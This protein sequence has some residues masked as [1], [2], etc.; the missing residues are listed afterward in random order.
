MPTRPRAASSPPASNAPVGFSIDGDRPPMP[1]LLH[2][3]IRKASQPTEP[4]PPTHRKRDF[5]RSIASMMDVRPRRKASSTSSSITLAPSSVSLHNEALS[6]PPSSFISPSF[7]SLSP[8]PSIPAAHSSVTLSSA[9]SNS[10]SDISIDDTTTTVDDAAPPSPTNTGGRSLK[11]MMSIPLIKFWARTSLSPTTF[12]P[13][14]SAEQELL[15]STTTQTT[16][17]RTTTTYQTPYSQSHFYQSESNISSNMTDTPPPLPVTK[18]S[19]NSPFRI[20][21][22]SPKPAPLPHQPPK[23][24]PPVQPR[25]K[26]K[27]FDQKR[28]PHIPSFYGAKAAYPGSTI[29]LLPILS[30]HTLPNTLTSED[31]SPYRHIKHDSETLPQKEPVPDFEAMIAGSATIKVSLTPEELEPMV[32]AY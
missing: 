15:P 4:P 2:P 31:S 9:K 10:S 29:A 24:D 6:P 22:R 1:M 20:R 14:P 32:V 18:H 8:P 27:S 13:P 12:T 16:A 23:S 28:R 21:C 25:H 17:S 5:F 7:E 19:T 3:K 26:A 11:K 30:A